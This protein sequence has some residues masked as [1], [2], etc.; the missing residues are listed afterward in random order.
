MVRRP[1]P[2]PEEWD[3]NDK[4]RTALHEAGHAVLAWSFR[5]TVGCIHLDVKRQ[6]GHA[7]IA[8]TTHLKHFEQIANWLAGFVA[9]EVFKP[10]GR[11]A[12]AIIDDG[13]VSRILR[14]NGT[15]D[16]T[17][18]GQR[19]RE[20]GRAYAEGRLRE[21]RSKVRRLARH[22]MEHHYIDRVDFEAMMRQ[23]AYD[24]VR[25]PFDRSPEPL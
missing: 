5:V 9:E 13:E 24:M 6:S 2:K 17:A 4:E 21:H 20:Q 22:L 18:E 14:E 3:P 7:K 12:K 19:L 11:K 23:K 8:P 1:A 10:P 15:P 16:D 25:P